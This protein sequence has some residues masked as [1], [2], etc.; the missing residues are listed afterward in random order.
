MGCPSSFQTVAAIRAAFSASGPSVTTVGV[1]SATQ[2]TVNGTFYIEDSPTTDGSGGSGIAV[3]APSGVITTA[4]AIGD[5]AMVTGSQTLYKGAKQLA[6]TSYTLIDVDYLLAPAQRVTNLTTLEPTSTA[7][8]PIVGMRVL[9][10]GT[11]VASA[12]CPPEMQY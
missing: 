11:L 3:Y 2:G 7:M 9:A 10:L 12:T 6:A 4:P 8:T 1:V 5:L